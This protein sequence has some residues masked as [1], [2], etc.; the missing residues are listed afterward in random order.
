MLNHAPQEGDTP[1]FLFLMQNG[2][3]FPEHPEASHLIILPIESTALKLQQYG[4]W[5]GR[6]LLTDIGGSSKHYT[7]AVDRVIGIDGKL[8]S[9]NHCTIWR[10]RGAFQSD[11]AARMQ[12]TLTSKFDKANHAPVIELNGTTGFEP[13]HID[14]VAGSDVELDASKTFDPDGDELSF[15]WIPYKDITATQWWVDAEVATLNIKKIDEA[16]R[17]VKITMPPPEKCCVNLMSRQASRKGQVFHVILEVKDGGIPSMRAYRRIMIQATNEA[18][19]G[20]GG[21][22]ADCI[23]DVKHDLL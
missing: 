7:D 2:L 23:A 9:N 20:G 22:A 1:T 11:F 19:L 4:G 14:A 3:N 10:W 18:M 6:Y 17:R 12:W 5:G 13:F 21:S 15:A 16:G 8:Y